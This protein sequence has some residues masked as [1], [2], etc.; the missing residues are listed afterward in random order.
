LKSVL[1][2][3]ISFSTLL[4]AV[5]SQWEKLILEKILSSMSS[6]KVVAVYTSEQSLLKRLEG[7]RS[8]RLVDDCQSADFVFSQERKVSYC[9]KPEIVFNYGVYRKK[10]TAVGV[11][12]WQKGRPTIRFSSKRL[13]HY[14]LRVQGELS[15]FVSAKNY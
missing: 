6:K 15:K 12:F 11:F 10:P 14:G 8:I 3:L 5:D 2:L 4:L 9:S 1:I 13:E 7:I